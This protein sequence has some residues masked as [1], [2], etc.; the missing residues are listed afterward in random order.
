MEPTRP[1]LALPQGMAKCS[2][3]G[4]SATVEGCSSIEAAEF[5]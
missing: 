1:A 5:V 3:G 2:Q 4:A